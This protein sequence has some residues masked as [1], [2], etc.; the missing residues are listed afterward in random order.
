MQTRHI[1]RLSWK[2]EREQRWLI[3]LL[4]LSFETHLLLY[5]KFS[6]ISQI[7]ESW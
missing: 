6:N 3:G 4:K 2:Y 1:T 7:E 5:N